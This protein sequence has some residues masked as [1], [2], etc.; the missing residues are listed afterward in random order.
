MN[1][2]DYLEFVQMDDL[3]PAQRELAELIG[4]DTFKTCCL[5]LGGEQTYFPVIESL[6]VQARN[7]MI[8]QEFDGAN[9]SQLARRCGLSGRTV[10]SIVKDSK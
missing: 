7:R 2:A 1:T 8:R 6:C 3:N 10:R 9:Y 4:L 5:Y